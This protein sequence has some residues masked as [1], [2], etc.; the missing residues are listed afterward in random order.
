MF[1][2]LF[3]TSRSFV[4]NFV[5]NSL[6]D[7][8]STFERRKRLQLLLFCSLVVDIHRRLYIAMPHNFLDYFDVGFVFAESRAERMPQVVTAK[9]WQK[10]RFSVLCGGSFFFLQICVPYDSL[11][12]PVDYVRVQ[13]FIKAVAED[14]VRIA[15]N[16]K[17]VEAVFRLTCIL[18]K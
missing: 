3:I 10:H 16:Y 7:S 17:R 4:V 15:V 8:E 18:G 12:R 2:Q 11:N 5:V 1:P 14:E 6:R 9:V 13:S